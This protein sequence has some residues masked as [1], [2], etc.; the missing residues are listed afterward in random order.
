MA[1]KELTPKQEAYK[2][3]LIKKFHVLLGKNGLGND[4]KEGILAGYGVEHTNELSAMQLEEACR[5][6]ENQQT[7]K[8]F[9][10][11]I[12]KWRKRAIGA[13][14]EVAKQL[15]YGLGIEGAKAMVLRACA[16]EFHTFN[17]IPQARLQAV[18]NA[19]KLNLKDFKET[20]K[21]IEE[22][23]LNKK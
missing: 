8:Q 2:K 17:A 20:D 19:F 22:L 23:I 14:F 1:T 4:A 12:D 7:K 11:D 21:L 5:T 6:L 9:S 16:K 3:Q 13:A 15:G 10:S 18:Y